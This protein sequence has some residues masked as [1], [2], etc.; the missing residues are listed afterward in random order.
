MKSKLN[1]LNSLLLLSGLIIG[2]VGINL[3]PS[4]AQDAVQENFNQQIQ[5]VNA[6]INQTNVRLDG[7]ADERLTLEQTIAGL[8]AEIAS[9]RQQIGNTKAEL[10][11]LEEAIEQKQQEIDEQKLILTE[12]LKVLYQR[13]DASALEL[14]ITSETFGEYVDR[15]EYLDRL[16]T[17]VSNSVHR[18]Q[19]LKLTLEAEEAKQAQLLGELE[20]QEI[21]L[22]AA[23]YEQQHLLETTR[24]QEDVFQAQLDELEAEYQR[25]QAELAVYLTSLISSQVSL[26]PVVNGAMIGRVGNTGWSTGPHL[27][28]EI[29]NA[30]ASRIDPLA[31]INANGLTWPVSGGGWISQGF[32]PGHHALDVAAQEG[33]PAVALASGTLIHRGCLNLGTD[34]ANFGVIIDHGNYYSLYAHLQAPNNPQYAAC[35][36]NRR[37]SYGTPSID[38]SVTN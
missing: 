18:I 26:G 33:T 16:K 19:E 27:H 36:I 25:L 1:Y 3:P 23:Q 34:F 20:G 13:S 9:L 32:H 12:I 24:G 2:L 14:L 4:L 5:N 29:Y 10:V 7:L 11:R 28:L 21:S 8:Q 37:S 22:L 31:F 6:Q 38:Y 30:G 15:Q 35:S 17:E